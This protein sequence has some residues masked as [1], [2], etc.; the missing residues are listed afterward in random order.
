MNGELSNL[1]LESK[2]FLIGNRFPNRASLAILIDS[3]KCQEYYE[4]AMALYEERKYEKDI[5]IFSADNNNPVLIPPSAVYYYNYLEYYRGDVLALTLR[6]ALNARNSGVNFGKKYWYIS[7]ISEVSSNKHFI[8][9]FNFFDKIFFV[10][11]EVRKV[12]SSIVNQIDL[13]KTEIADL[14]IILNKV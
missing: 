3:V 11:E 9:L 2:T 12:F 13:G 10:N 14:D 1:N 5:M 7:D 8:E 6:G 4:I